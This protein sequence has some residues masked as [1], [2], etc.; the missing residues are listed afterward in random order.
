MPLNANRMLTF[1]CRDISTNTLRHATSGH[2]KQIKWKWLK[3]QNLQG[4]TCIHI[5][6][7]AGVG[8]VLNDASHC[9]LCEV[10]QHLHWSVH[11]W[12]PFQQLPWLTASL[13]LGFGYYY[14]IQTTGEDL[15]P[16]LV[17]TIHVDDDRKPA[18]GPYS[19]LIQRHAV[20][21]Q[22]VATMSFIIPQ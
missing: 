4:S 2:R 19:W 1:C 14:V 17:G 18:N 11:D 9:V 22:S 16:P 8:R 21:T 6:I 20:L 7:V 10:L 13:S 15:L 3:Q 5:H 12:A